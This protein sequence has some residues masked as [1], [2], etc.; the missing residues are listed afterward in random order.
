MKMI[1]KL[2]KYY[3]LM[4]FFKFKNIFCK[5]NFF[6]QHKYKIFL[7]S[8]L[9]FFAILLFFSLNKVSASRIELLSFK[10]ELTKEN[11]C[12]EECRRLRQQQKE[13]IAINLST[14]KLLVDDFKKYFLSAASQKDDNSRFLWQEL[15]QISTLS[16]QLDYLLDF[17]I[18]YLI[19]EEGNELVKADII[20]FV[21]ADMSDINL[22]KYYFI[23]LQSNSSSAL[24][25]ES[26]RALS[27]VSQKELF[28]Q[29]EQL[30]ILKGLIL[31]DGTS[32]SLKVD[33]LF[34]LSDYFLLFP[35]EVKNVFLDI[36][37]E[38]KEAPIKILAG[39]FLNNLGEM[40][41]LLPDINDSEWLPYF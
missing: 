27:L 3:I 23:I 32:S 41:L 21:L 31:K 18:D 39:T 4:V 14:D 8:L 38:S 33:T 24:K 7:F 40:R 6:C 34:L 28:F 9:I 25:I 35:E 26:I 10:Q 20:R 11:I 12:H 1:K 22:V 16:S 15:L 13:R 5:K 30:N 17:F 29:K 36:Y 37:Y 19:N 2:I